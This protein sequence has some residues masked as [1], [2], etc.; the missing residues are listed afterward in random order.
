MSLASRGAEFFRFCIVGGLTFLVDYGLLFLL[1][2]VLD[3]HYLWSSAWAFIVAVIV[4]YY[5]CVF[6]VFHQAARS[7]ARQVVFVGSSLAGLGINQI[8]MW[9][10]V[11]KLALHYMLAKVVATG[12]VMIWNYIMKRKALSLPG[13]EAPQPFRCVLSSVV[14][15]GKSRAVAR[16][17][18]FTSEGLAPACSRRRTCLSCPAAAEVTAH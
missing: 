7:F 9:L 4:N 18:S 3:V 1:T 6:F 17:S 14:Q 10:L 15:N 8:C 11:D 13:R 5:L 12:V 2:S 16:L